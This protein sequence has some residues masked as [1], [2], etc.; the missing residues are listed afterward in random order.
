MRKKLLARRVFRAAMSL[1][2]AMSSQL[3]CLADCAAQVRMGA[4]MG[5]LEAHQASGL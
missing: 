5:I 4:E 2:I 1:I 3:I